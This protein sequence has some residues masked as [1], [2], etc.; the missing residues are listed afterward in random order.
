MAGRDPG[1]SGAPTEPGG[2]GEGGKPPEAPLAGAGGSDPAAADELARAKDRFKR[3]L[4][5]MLE[6][7]DV[8]AAV[9][10]LCVEEIL[11]V[12]DRAPEAKA[13]LALQP[14]IEAAVKKLVRPDALRQPW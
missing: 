1:K 14:T 4:L 10:A 2:G 5:V 12:A 13:P 3:S 6:D 7:P 8:R 11:T 9:K